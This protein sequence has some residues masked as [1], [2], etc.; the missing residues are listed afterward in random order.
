MSTRIAP[1]SKEIYQLSLRSLNEGQVK[2]VD[3]SGTCQKLT[4]TTLEA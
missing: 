2:T 4:A 1:T 3:N